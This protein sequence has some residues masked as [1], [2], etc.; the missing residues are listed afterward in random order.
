MKTKASNGDKSNYKYSILLE[1]FIN[2]K[3]NNSKNKYETSKASIKNY[4]RNMHSYKV[5][6]NDYKDSSVY[7][8]KKYTID[9][10][11]QKNPGNAI[12]HLYTCSPLLNEIRSS[13][14][15]LK[16]ALPISKNEA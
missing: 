10:H 16:K 14:S 2:K 3:K 12:I 9:M 5:K 11:T 13:H 4:F 15:Y 7:S 1:D 6:N 8:N